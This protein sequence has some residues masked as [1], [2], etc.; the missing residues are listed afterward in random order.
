MH[1]RAEGEAGLGGGGGRDD[2]REGVD[3]ETHT[4][5]WHQRQWGP[6]LMRRGIARGGGGESEAGG[7]DG[8]DCVNSGDSGVT[9]R[10][11]LCAID[12][13]VENERGGGGR[14]RRRRQRSADF[15]EDGGGAR[16]FIVNGAGERL[17]ES[18]RREGEACM[19]ECA[20][21]THRCNGGFAGP[22]AAGIAADGGHEGGGVV[23]HSL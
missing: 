18:L 6:R 20:P 11:I 15:G 4:I 9:R 8:D 10:R 7:G 17:S 16:A 22:R 2:G 13:K 21:R 3:E 19:G 12:E 14:E 1:S 5:K 23:G